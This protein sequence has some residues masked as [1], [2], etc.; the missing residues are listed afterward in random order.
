MQLIAVFIRLEV[1][2]VRLLIE[3]SSI[4][5]QYSLAGQLHQASLLVDGFGS[6][7]PGGPYN[8]QSVKPS[9]EKWLALEI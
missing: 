2:L 9:T 3:S 7:I 6:V 1:V 4:I 5:D 8:L